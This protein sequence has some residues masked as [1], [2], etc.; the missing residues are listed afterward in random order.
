MGLYVDDNDY[1]FNSAN[2]PDTII[3]LLFYEMDIAFIFIFIL[4]FF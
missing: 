2:F 4:H 3:S 1:L